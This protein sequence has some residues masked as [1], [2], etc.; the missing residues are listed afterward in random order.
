M[1]EFEAVLTDPDQVLCQELAFLD[2]ITPEQFYGT[3]ATLVGVV[4]A[5]YDARVHSLVSDL[6]VQLLWLAQSEPRV[7]CRDRQRVRKLVMEMNPTDL[8]VTSAKL[9]TLML[10]SFREGAESGMIGVADHAL[11][12]EWRQRV[13]ESAQIVESANSVISYMTKLARKIDHPLLA[14][15]F[16]QKQRLLNHGNSTAACLALANE[17]A[18]TCNTT[19][20]GAIAGYRDRW[21]DLTDAHHPMPLQPLPLCDQAGQSH[22]VPA[23]DGD[24]PL[25]QCGLFRTKALAPG[26]TIA[27]LEASA[28]AAVRWSSAWC[29]DVAVKC[30]GASLEYAASG[31]IAYLCISK[32]RNLGK[33]QQLDIDSAQDETLVARISA[34]FSFTSS[35]FAIAA[36]WQSL[37]TRK[38]P[39]RRAICSANLEWRSPLEAV[40][41]GGARPVLVSD[42]K[43]DD[44]KK[45][46]SKRK[47][48]KPT[49]P[50]KRQKQEADRGDPADA[51][52]RGRRGGLSA[53]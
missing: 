35:A 28:I 23:G 10:E 32:L 50:T 18:N 45:Q 6:P 2:R 17:V 14:S 30:I 5:E 52:A 39:C 19:Q 31:D 1:R 21:L 11:L 34:P 26:I 20:H 49:R 43:A 3:V 33:L 27:S 48:S 40:L 13:R 4:A 24:L 12:S 16:T 37:Q 7:H 22:Q 25:R 44:R 36:A 8:D 47:P 41:K 38:R 53:R 51:P 29:L 15:R 9:E 42:I 46:Q